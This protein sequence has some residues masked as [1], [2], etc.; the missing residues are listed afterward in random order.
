MRWPAAALIVL[1]TTACETERSPAPPPQPPPAYAYAPPYAYPP[2]AAPAPASPDGALARSFDLARAGDFVTFER[3]LRIPQALYDAQN[4]GGDSFAALTAKMQRT[5]ATFRAIA[6]SPLALYAP[7]AHDADGFACVTSRG[8]YRRADT[9]QDAMFT[10][11]TTTIGGRLFVID[12][13][14]M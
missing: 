7:R 1:A 13:W 9:G 3:E 2:P 11:R 8:R 6:G 5:F 4:R 14:A 12:L 10:V